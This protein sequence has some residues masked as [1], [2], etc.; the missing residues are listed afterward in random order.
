MLNNNSLNIKTGVKLRLIIF[1]SIIGIL[2]SP[3]LLYPI[4]NLVPPPILLVVIVL[5]F[6]SGFILLYISEKM[7]GIEITQ[8]D[9]RMTIIYGDL[10]KTHLSFKQDEL[11]QFKAKFHRFEG[12]VGFFNALVLKTNNPEQRLNS[13]E[14][15]TILLKLKNQK[16][17]ECNT[18]LNKE[19]CKSVMEVIEGFKAQSFPLS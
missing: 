1:G 2:W 7:Q 14:K 12:R 3:V 9:E 18:Y 11:M 17:I 6:S 8:T 5:I 4:L 19:E 16:T 13:S 10:Y 15:Y